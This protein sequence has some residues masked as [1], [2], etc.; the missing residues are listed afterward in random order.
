MEPC[1]LKYLF[2][3]KPYIT[4]ADTANVQS[5]CASG[6]LTEGPIT[7]QFEDMVAQYVGAKYAVAVCNCT[8]ALELA[9]RAYDALDSIKDIK[10]SVHLPAFTHPAT[11]RAAINAGM[12]PVLC[13]VDSATYNMATNP[14][15][16][17]Y[18]ALMPV[19]WGGYPI[20]YNGDEGF[21]V[22][23]AACSLGSHINGVKTGSQVTACFSFHPRKLVTTGEG[24]MVV[25]NNR[26]VAEAVR[27]MKNFGR[28]NYKLSDVNSAL[29]LSQLKRIDEIIA[30][31]RKLAKVYDDLLDG[32]EL[33][34][35]PPVKD[36]VFHTYQTY[37]VY[38]H[39][40]NRDRIIRHMAAGGI[41]TQVGAYALHLLP[42]YV[43]T[44][45]IGELKNSTKLHRKL[46]A[47]P[48][49]YDLNETD[50][51]RVI[52]DLRAFVA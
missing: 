28:G 37:A 41:E 25:T 35:P 39:R 7:K 19:S 13:D 31:R 24:G 30:Q 42:E 3:N 8:I 49:A 21:F 1:L 33:I 15:T 45:R 6:W 36:G 38:L 52:N 22:E 32:N 29:G 9:L 43:D 14:S 47:L 46:L 44:Q 51:H 27:R 26:E 12:M 17:K 50:Q 10:F 48:M 11:I 16:R 18:G 5:V 4:D 23:D 40:G 20:P 34:T 2:L